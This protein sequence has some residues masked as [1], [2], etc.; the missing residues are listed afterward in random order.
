M[1]QIDKRS[2]HEM[3][4]DE[5]RILIMNQDVADEAVGIVHFMPSL[6]YLVFARDATEASELRQF[7]QNQF[8]IELKENYA[9]EQISKRLGIIALSFGEGYGKVKASGKVLEALDLNEARAAM[10]EI[11]PSI[12]REA[13]HPDGRIR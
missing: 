11:Q 3:S 6:R 10:S 9:T 2:G 5:R 13:N 4:S 1:W 8:R 7:F 12:K